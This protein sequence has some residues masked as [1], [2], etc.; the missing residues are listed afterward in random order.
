A[1]RPR[2]RDG[3]PH[4]LRGRARARA[5]R[6]AAGARGRPP[7]RARRRRAAR[8]QRQ[9]AGLGQGPHRRRAQPAGLLGLSRIGEPMIAVGRCRAARP[10]ALAA[11]LALAALGAARAEPWAP[12]HTVRIIVPIIGS[13]NDTLA[14][15]VAPGLSEALG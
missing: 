1:D 2:D 15:L 13:T 5:G 10:V 6:R 8:R 4:A 12:R 11:A 9:A 3:A 7:A 14:R